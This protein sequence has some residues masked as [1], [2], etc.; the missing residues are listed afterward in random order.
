MPKLHLVYPDGTEARFALD[1]DHLTIGRAE[2]ND[3]VLPDLRSSSH[4]LALK[5]LASGEYV[6]NDLGATNPTRINGKASAVHELK[7]G[8]TL[9]IGDTYAR[10]ESSAAAPASAPHQPPGR[11]QRPAGASPTEAQGKGCFALI[12]VGFFLALGGAALA[13]VF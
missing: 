5:R 4:H 7:H 6:A 2:D 9:L 11:P 3:I 10:Y 13:A 1:G 8:D 12:A